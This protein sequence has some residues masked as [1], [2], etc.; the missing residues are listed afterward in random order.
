MQGKEVN[1]A[2]VL[3]HLAAEDFIGRTREM[4][5]VLRYAKGQTDSKGML[6]L[7]A[8]ACGLSEFLRQ[9]YDQLFYEQGDIIP[10]YFSFSKNDKTAEQVGK[11]FLQAFLLQVVAFR[12]GAAHLLDSAPDICEIAEVAVPADGVWIDRL[13][14]A[15]ESNSRLKDERSFVKQAFSAPLRAKAHEANIFVMFDNFEYVENIKGEINLL[16]ELKEIYERSAVPFVFAGRR[17]YVLNAIQSGTTRLQNADVLRLRSLETSDAILLTEHLAE[18][19][20]VKINPQTLDLI[21]Q[22][23]DSN[24]VSLTSIFLSAQE[25]GKNLDS[26]QKVEQLYVDS[27]LGG[28]ICRFFETHVDEI[29]ANLQIQKKIIDLLANEE[30]R[31]PVETWRNRLNI[32]ET[33][34]RR[35]INLLHVH[36]II[37]LNSGMVEF[38]ADNQILSDYIEARYRL[39]IVGEGRALVVGKLLADSL[40]RAP[41]TMTRFYRHSSAIGLREI[42]SV[43][44]CQIV[45]A[46]LLDY[47]IFKAEHKGAE[48]EEI[49]ELAERE[50]K[51]ITLPQIVYTANCVA[52]YPPINQFSDDERSAVALGFETGNYSDENEIVWITAEIDSKLEASAE[53]TEFW[54]DRLEMVALMCNFL[55]YSLWLIT[56]EGF[57]P[58][59]LEILN[60][61]KAFGSSRKQV[62]LL[63]KQLK[64]ENL[65]KERLNPNEYEMIVPMGDDTEMI[66]AHAVEEIARRHDFQPRA[67]NQIKTALVEACINAS[68]HSLSPDRKIYQKFTV[69]DDKIIITISNRGVK[70]PPKK[71]AESITEIEPN[72]GRRGWGL[73]LMRNLMDEVKFE[74]VDD[75]T[76]ISM[77]KYLKK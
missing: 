43:F 68:E 39:E 32:G 27:V 21:I 47:K 24:P 58:E 31:T 54:C 46:S 8:P 62:E 67:I 52:F 55:N 34:F 69:E 70:I 53:L 5:E 22:Q 74:Q 75:G 38:S 1:R 2:K 59:A 77:V 3:S 64:A 41:Q 18:K 6:V 19:T 60:Q 51:K 50:N 40:K 20:Q 9:T 61:R 63:I 48:E 71:Q 49:L 36:E 11:R 72:E 44:N 15:C 25:N 57:S 33:E 56:P 42:L 26:F 35:I 7:S 65:L 29:T 30:K 16:D 76:R 12:R 14:S 66:A 10:I 23:F 45:P 13:I 28:R 4:D 37:R 73:K 17:R